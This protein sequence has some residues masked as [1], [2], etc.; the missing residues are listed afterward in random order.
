AIRLCHAVT[1]DEQLVYRGHQVPPV[2]MPKWTVV[3]PL[4][5]FAWSPDG[6]VIASKNQSPGT[7]HLWDAATGELIRQTPAVAAVYYHLAWSP[8]SR[9]LAGQ[10]DDL[11]LHIWNV[12]T[13]GVCDSYRGHQQRIFSFA[14]SPDG[15][16][17]ASLSIDHQL[18]IW[19]P[20]L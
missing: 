17:M 6:R 10:A 13:G 18:H 16:Q 1:G 3:N 4:Q 20:S 5:T 2:H 9:W 7:I 12:R 11:T 8:D 19:T 15:Q 14:W